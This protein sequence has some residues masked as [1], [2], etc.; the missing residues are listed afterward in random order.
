MY[1]AVSGAMRFQNSKYTYLK[2]KGP[3][4]AGEYTM[5]LSIDPNRL[6]KMDKAGNLYSGQGIERI[7]QG[8]LDSN[9]WGNYRVRL[10][11]SSGTITHGRTNFY[12]HDSHKGFTRGCIET[13]TAFFIKLLEYRK[14]SSKLTLYV[15]Y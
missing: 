10:N 14:N 9:P 6:A 15:K 7:P 1:D 12:I 11:P 4:P 5:D 8:F 13:E 3:I 2:N